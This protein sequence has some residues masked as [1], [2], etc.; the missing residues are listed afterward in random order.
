MTPTM[1]YTCSEISYSESRYGQLPRWAHNSGDNSWFYLSYA[2]PHETVSQGHR[3]YFLDYDVQL[4][5][6][7]AYFD[8]LK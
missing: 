2:N 7:V 5:A 3:E 6:F 8:D 1:L 4:T